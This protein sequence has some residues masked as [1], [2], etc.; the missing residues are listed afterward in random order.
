MDI[1]KLNKV[2]ARFWD[3]NKRNTMF[4]LGMCSEFAVALQKYLGGKGE[5]TK[6]GLFH[7]VLKYNGLYCDVRGCQT[8]EQLNFKMPIGGVGGRD[9][10]RKATQKEIKHIYSLLNKRNVKYIYEGLKQA[11]KEV[12]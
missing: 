4:Y 11:E 9:T 1:D 8:Y 3:N 2:I 7:T 12:K 6:H 5:I 10:T